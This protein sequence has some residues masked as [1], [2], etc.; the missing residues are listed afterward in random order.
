[1]LNKAMLKG[2]IVMI[3]VFGILLT[4][5][6]P[7][8]LAADKKCKKGNYYTA[9]YYDDA[10][11]ERDR[12]LR[13]RRNR[14]YDDDYYRRDR[15]DSTGKTLRDVGIGAAIGAGGGAIIIE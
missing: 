11:Y 4:T 6:A 15:R 10:Y 8:A 5:A 7:V 3:L 14:D 1:M 9:N 12:D 13:R 2:A